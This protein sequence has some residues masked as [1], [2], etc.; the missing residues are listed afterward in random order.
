ME[1]FFS[2]SEET[3]TTR[4][5]ALLILGIKIKLPEIFPACRMR[6]GKEI[7]S[8]TGFILDHFSTHLNSFSEYSS[9]WLLLESLIGAVSSLEGKNRWTKMSLSYRSTLH[10][11]GVA[12]DRWSVRPSEALW[13]NF[14]IK[15]PLPQDILV[16]SQNINIF[17]FPRHL[18]KL[19][20]SPTTH[21]FITYKML[22]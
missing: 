18:S 10:C 6:Q 16:Q 2:H 15:T 7:N 14:F 13:E 9:C 12:G 4:S 11:S 22:N 20:K 17:L 8:G 19:T 1:L 5:I 21:I 3:V